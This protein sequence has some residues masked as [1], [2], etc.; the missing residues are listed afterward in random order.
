MSQRVVL[1]DFIAQEYQ[2]APEF[3]WRNYPD[4][5][6]FRHA[7]NRKWFAI[8]MTVSGSLVGLETAEKIDVMNV[9]LPP[10][11]VAQLSGQ[12][13]FAPAYHMNKRHWLSV[14]LDDRL[15][16]KQLLDLLHTSWLQT[17]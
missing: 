15:P 1:T 9:K 4:Y 3:L 7:E 14:L 5:A 16:E 17:R 6:V 11:W 2:V 10:E 13:G 12:A 8:M